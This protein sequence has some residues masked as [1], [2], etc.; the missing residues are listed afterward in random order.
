MKK[1]SVG[2]LLLAASM[3]MGSLAGCSQKAAESTAAAAASEPAK[4]AEEASK[5]ADNG[6]GGGVKMPNS[7]RMRLP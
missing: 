2:I 5:N 3:A 4:E 6:G 1:K 7:L